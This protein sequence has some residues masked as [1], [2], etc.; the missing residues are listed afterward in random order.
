M[1]K[2][3]LICVKYPS[4]HNFVRGSRI[5]LLGGSEKWRDDFINQVNELW[6][7]EDINFFFIDD[8]EKMDIERTSWLMN[9]ISLTDFLV[10]YV[11]DKKDPN[12]LINLGFAG[13]NIDNSNT[14]VLFDETDDL[15]IVQM[16]YSSYNKNN[17]CETE[18]EVIVTMRDMYAGMIG[19]DESL[20]E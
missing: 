20:N 1:S 6:I 11:E 17:F 19:F 7:E 8:N 2:T 3:N 15:N 9:Q 10:I 12:T 16:L 18:S 14:F 5:V 4:N 13:I